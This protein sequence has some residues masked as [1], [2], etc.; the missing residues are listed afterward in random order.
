[1]AS[2][3]PNVR[4]TPESG[5]QPKPVINAKPKRLTPICYPHLLKTSE[6]N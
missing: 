4:F 3:L 5:H 1:M 2:A 6:E